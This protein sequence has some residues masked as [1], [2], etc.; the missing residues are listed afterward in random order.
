MARVTTPLTDTKIKTAKAKDKDYK[1]FDGGGLF[2]LV[3]KR[4]T[5]L[6]RLKY[7]FDGKEKLLSLGA[8]PSISLIQAR[9]LREQ[10][11]S[12]IANVINPN[13]VKKEKKQLLQKEEIKNLNTF[14]LIALQRLDKVRDEISES[15]H[16]RMMGGFRNDV[17]PFIGDKPLDDIEASDVIN[18]LQVMMERGVRNSA[19]QVYSSI[20]KLLSGVSLMV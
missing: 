1:L 4:N 15:H 5:K 13:E 9:V 19:K 8:Y 3:T 10:H 20:N 11:K 2:L 7:R 18:I 16:K 17:F 14:Q 6:W 12:D